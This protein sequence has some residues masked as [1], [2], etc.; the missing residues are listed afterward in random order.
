[1]INA[2]GSVK[3]KRRIVR[4][5]MLIILIVVMLL[6]YPFEVG[7]GFNF[8]PA[9]SVD[10]YSQVSGEVKEVL[11]REGDRV[12]EGQLLALLDTREHQMNYDVINADLDKAR[13]DLR[14]LL[15]GAKAEEIDKA[16][17]QVKSAK[18]RGLFLPYPM[19]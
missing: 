7:G 19:R 18:K 12:K 14:L 13:A 4:W 5:L 15:A 9:E 17:Q 6:P 8:L 11:V 1:M 10:V 16:R 2:D 3:K